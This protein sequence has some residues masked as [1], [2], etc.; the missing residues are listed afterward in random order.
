[1][2]QDLPPFIYYNFVPSC[3]QCMAFSKDSCHSPMMYTCCY[4]LLIQQ[5]RTTQQQTSIDQEKKSL[6]EPGGSSH[7]HTLLVD[8]CMQAK[9]C[10]G[11]C[12]LAAATLLSS[13]TVPLNN[14]SSADLCFDVSSV[15]LKMTEGITCLMMHTAVTVGGQMESSLLTR[16]KKRV[17]VKLVRE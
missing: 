13:T 15:E 1:M 4:C 8:P 16:I 7:Y 6:N 2:S 11:G 17:R 10:S 14:R 9:N 12:S 3:Y 5:P